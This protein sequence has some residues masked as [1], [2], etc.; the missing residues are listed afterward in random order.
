MG[1]R[2]P[3]GLCSVGVRISEEGQAKSCQSPR[4]RSAHASW[5]PTRKL[6]AQDPSGSLQGTGARRV[7]GRNTRREDSAILSFCSPLQKRDKKSLS[8]V[9]FPEAKQ[10]WTWLLPGR[11]RP[12]SPLTVDGIE[13]S[14]IP[15][16]QCVPAR[17]TRWEHSGSQAYVVQLLSHV[18]FFATMDCTRQAP[19]SST[20]PWSL[21]TSMSVE[22]LML[23]NHLILCRPSSFCL[24]SFPASGSCSVS[25]LLASGVQSIGDSASASV[26]PMNIQG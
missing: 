9:L 12:L 18:Q 3:Q 7:R 26:L 1:P 17:Q 20:I 25:W 14:C 11:G 23:S 21:L 13:K 10:A 24:H 6:C 19:L 4:G 8:L 22:S 5:A 16:P 2:G 15:E